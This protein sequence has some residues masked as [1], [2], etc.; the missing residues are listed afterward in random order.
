MA[1]TKQ[2]NLV[3]QFDDIE[4]DTEKIS[5]RPDL[6]DKQL[7][8]GKPPSCLWE[9]S[10][11]R[12]AILDLPNEVLENVF[13]YICDVSLQGDPWVDYA[14]RNCSEQAQA[15]RLVCRR[16]CIASSHWLIRTIDVKT[17]HPTDLKRLREVSLHP[18]IRKGVRC[19]RVS[20]E[21]YDPAWAES[22]ENFTWAVSDALL[23]YLGKE[24][25]TLLIGNPVEDY[26]NRRIQAEELIYFLNKH[27]P[28]GGKVAD[29]LRQK[30]PHMAALLEDAYS[31][32]R[33][34]MD[35]QDRVL[36]WG[37]FASV[38]VESMLR[39]PN[40]RSLE[41]RDGG[42]PFVGGRLVA[43]QPV[44]TEDLL[45]K[46]G[47]PD[48]FKPL[49]SI[50]LPLGTGAIGKQE[51]QRL[52]VNPTIKLLIAH[53]VAANEMKL[54]LKALSIN[55]TWPNLTPAYRTGFTEAGQAAMVA[56][57]RQLEQFT[58]AANSGRFIYGEPSMSPE[59]LRFVQKL[60]ASLAS[61]DNLR[62]IRLF[63][64]CNL[65]NVPDHPVDNP[66][67]TFLP[68]KHYPHL[69]DLRLSDVYVD[70]EDLRHLAQ[71]IFPQLLD[72][73]RCR[74]WNL[75]LLDDFWNEG[76]NILKSGGD[77]KLRLKFHNIDGANGDTCP[78]E[79]L[80]EVFGESDEGD[81]LN[82]A[83]KYILGYSDENPFKE[84]HTP[85]AS[86]DEGSL[87]DFQ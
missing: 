9:P 5:T 87:F 44:F 12:A 61:G 76:L 50:V 53:F 62:A 54:G 81:G 51:F 28:P 38:V 84:S 25:N 80:E 8:V 15:L 46:A 7:V 26:R 20:L 82:M 36:G 56:I 16:F 31:Q 1:A 67:S 30:Q 2:D 79:D 71:V 69:S 45:A 60:I 58:F 39:M 32:Y 42:H 55:F 3:S 63:S 43:R 85:E 77:R 21:F 70:T 65:V 52:T 83:E 13:S 27:H 48:L 23:R 22:M 24:E 86:S 14:R 57:A 75:S 19:V 10:S 11:R 66:L 74:L 33:L 73:G 40:A 78:E 37:S 6:Q 18:T 41:F 49:S 64:L 35:E 29:H 4:A 17:S 47:L 68:P 72:R 59:R 34:F